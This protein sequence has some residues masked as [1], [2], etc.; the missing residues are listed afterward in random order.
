[1]IPKSTILD[2]RT[3]LLEEEEKRISLVLFVAIWMPFAESIE[4]S[5]VNSQE[6]EPFVIDVTLVVN[7][8]GVGR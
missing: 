3:S 2:G 7:G 1:M 5:C 8:D 6:K 4:S